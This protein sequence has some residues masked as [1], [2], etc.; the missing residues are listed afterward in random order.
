MRNRSPFAKSTR[1]PGYSDRDRIAPA[2][3]GDLLRGATVKL[4]LRCQPSTLHVFRRREQP[5]KEWRTDDEVTPQRKSWWSRLDADTRDNI[6]V[7]VAAAFYAA[8]LAWPIYNLLLGPSA[9][10]D[11]TLLGGMIGLM[12]ASYAVMSNRVADVFRLPIAAAGLLIVLA[13]WGFGPL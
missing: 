9:P 5:M 10:E 2:G 12:L 3:M 6:I 1:R 13:C 4:T 11:F 7:G 8:L